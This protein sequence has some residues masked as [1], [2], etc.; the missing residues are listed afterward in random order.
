MTAAASFFRW[1]FGLLLGSEGSRKHVL[2][3][4]ALT[5]IYA[6]GV[7]AGA[8]EWVAEWLTYAALG[9]AGANVGEWAMRRR[10]ST[11]TPAAAAPSPHPPAAAGDGASAP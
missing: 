2:G 10:A 6:A 11:P 8:P 3:M 5:L 7:Q 1:L 4:Y 9:I